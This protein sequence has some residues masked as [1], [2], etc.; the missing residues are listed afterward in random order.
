MSIN[1]LNMNAM[2]P[3]MMSGSETSAKVGSGVWEEFSSVLTKQIRETDRMSK[4]AKEMGRRA[5]MGNAGVSIHEAQIAAAEA[6]LHLKFMMQV[7]N[8]AVEVY[9]EVMSM[10]V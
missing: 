3:Q 9:K 2:M 7:R 10:G 1:P 4:N 6:E 5:L 8:K